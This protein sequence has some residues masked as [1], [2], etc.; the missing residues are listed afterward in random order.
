[1]SSH[2]FWPQLQ[3]LGVRDNVH[4]TLNSHTLS[5]EAALDVLAKMHLA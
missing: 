1:M 5:E 4:V 3:V 2:G